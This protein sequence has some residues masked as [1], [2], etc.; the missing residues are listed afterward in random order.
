MDENLNGQVNP[1]N[2]NAGRGP[3]DPK[4]AWRRAWRR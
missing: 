2:G 4:D 1:E 3:E